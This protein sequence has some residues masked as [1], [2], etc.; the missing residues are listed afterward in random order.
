MVYIELKIEFELFLVDSNFLIFGLLG[1]SVSRFVE[2]KK[3]W[4]VDSCFLALHKLYSTTT[5]S[6]L[7][8]GC[9]ILISF[10]VSVAIVLLLFKKSV[11]RFY[12]STEGYCI[13]I[14]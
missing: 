6:F 8:S 4:L 11:V 2:R 3:P 10:V 7:F 12:Y 1:E 14:L 5:S 9:L 13:S